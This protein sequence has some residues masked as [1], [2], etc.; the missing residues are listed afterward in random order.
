MAIWSFLRGYSGTLIGLNGNSRCQS[1]CDKGN[2]GVSVTMSLEPH[3]W[4]IVSTIKALTKD[5]LNFAAHYLSLGATHLL[6][7]FGF[8]RSR[9]AGVTGKTPKY[10]GTNTAPDYWQ[11]RG[12]RPQP[13]ERRQIKNIKPQSNLPAATMILTGPF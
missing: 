12:R 8:P 4:A 6:S 9:G 5:I 1:D 13:V 2:D 3:R 10:T 11:A 7:A